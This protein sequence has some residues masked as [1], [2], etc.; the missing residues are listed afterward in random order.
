MDIKVSVIIPCYNVE[1]FLQ[2]CIDSLLAQTLNDIEFIFIN[3]ASP[4]NSL[5]IL[6]KNQYKYPGKIKVVDLKHNICQGGARNKGIEIA[7]GEYIGFV[8]SDDMVLPEMYEMLYNEAA[9]AKADAAFIQY[10]NIGDSCL[11]IYQLKRISEPSMHG[12]MY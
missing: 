5:D 10:A 4:D 2:D 9:L 6:L 11:K 3:D 1:R 8:D 12:I 7:R